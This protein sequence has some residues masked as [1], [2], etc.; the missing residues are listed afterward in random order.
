MDSPACSVFA[1]T[2]LKRCR[3]VSKTHDVHV[4]GTQRPTQTPLTEVDCEIDIGRQAFPSSEIAHGGIYIGIRLRRIIK[5]K[6]E[7]RFIAR[8]EGATSCGKGRLWGVN[9]QIRRAVPKNIKIWGNRQVV[10]GEGLMTW[11]YS[12]QSKI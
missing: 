7:T 5:E 6:Q 11:K 8:P 3:R 4:L 9:L 2:F 12:L 1:C 10:K